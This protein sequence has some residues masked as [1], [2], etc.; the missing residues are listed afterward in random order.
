MMSR[1]MGSPIFSAGIDGRAAVKMDIEGSEWAALPTI[2]ERIA[3]VYGE[4]HTDPA[5]PDPAAKLAAM[6]TAV[7]MR[8]LPAEKERFHWRRD[9]LDPGSAGETCDHQWWHARGIRKWRQTRGRTRRCPGVRVLDLTR[10]L[11]GPYC[12]QLLGDLG[13]DVIKIER[14]GVRG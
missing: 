6:A 13:A 14:P 3:E 8:S 5:V 7:G 12:T 1:P 9:Q 4:W 2:D 10:I 11:A